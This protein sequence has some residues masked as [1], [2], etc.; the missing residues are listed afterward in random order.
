MRFLSMIPVLV[1]FLVV[2]C[3]G[4]GSEGD[5]TIECGDETC[6]ASSE[7]CYLV[8]NSDLVERHSTCKDLPS[9]CT[10][11]SCA[12]DDSESDCEYSSNGITYLNISCSQIGKKIVV[13]C[14]DN[15]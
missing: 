14:V 5:D 1:V 2:A 4:D 13:V 7:Y 12:E 3:G 8:N 15:S 11:C 10:S 6:T 9:G